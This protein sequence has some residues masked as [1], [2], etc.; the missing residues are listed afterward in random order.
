MP[1]FYSIFQNGG[2][3]RSDSSEVGPRFPLAENAKEEF[4]KI[5][6]ELT[7]SLMERVQKDR[8]AFSEYLLLGRLFRIRGE[9]RRALKLHQNLLA[10]PSYDRRFEATLYAELGWDMHA[11]RLRDFG[12]EHFQK[13]VSLDK[14][15]LSALEGLAQAFEAQENFEEACK[16]VKRLVKAEADKPAH[17]AFLCSE[18]AA[19]YLQKGEKVKARRAVEE[20]LRADRRNPYALLTLADVYLEAERY[21]QAIGTLLGFLREWKGLSFLALRRLEDAH[22]RK[23]EFTTY[24]VTLREAI[25]TDPENF[26]LHF[27][28]AR[29]LMKKKRDDEAKEF[30]RRSLE[31]NPGYVN[32]VR[33]MV[34]LLARGE[35]AE[36]T[37]LRSV[38]GQFFQIFKRSRRFIC[39]N[40]GK[41]HIPVTWQCSACGA[42]DVPLIR[43]ELTAP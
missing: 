8:E 34:T 21:S 40:C 22:Y 4:R 41:R 30:L 39:P 1:E 24:E 10:H 36:T 28:L 6:Q 2:L 15:N 32:P 43:Y 19:R 29:H 3:P 7:D 27:S 17:L 18:L 33:D 20:A 12:L 11:C 42:W 31:I 26:Y 23:N 25:R 38:L 9:A 16:A 37:R 35:G 13:A 14:H 5:T